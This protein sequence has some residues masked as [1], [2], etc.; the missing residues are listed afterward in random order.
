MEM[1]AGFPGH[2]VSI[3]RA[4][5]AGSPRQGKALVMASSRTGLKFEEASAHMRRL[6]GSRGDKGRQDVLFTEEAS[7]PPE[8]DENLEAWTAYWAAKENGVGK[9]RQDGVPRR[10]GDKVRGGWTNRRAGKLNG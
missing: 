5:N 4:N 8:S 6:S 7:G 1:G 10:G 9:K 2:F 3:L